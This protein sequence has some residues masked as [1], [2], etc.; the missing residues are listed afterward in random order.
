MRVKSVAGNCSAGYKEGDSF[1]VEEPNIVPESPGHFCY[2]AIP[3]LITYLNAYVR[4]TP[5]K[6]WINKLSVL[7]CPDA[8]NTVVFEV[9]RLS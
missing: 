3:S 1:I 9:E 2:Y 4:D 7:Q 8:K 6:D 5:E